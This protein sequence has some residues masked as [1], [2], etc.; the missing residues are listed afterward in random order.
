MLEAERAMLK[1]ERERLEDKDKAWIESEVTASLADC[2]AGQEELTGAEGT[3]FEAA[4][5]PVPPTR[6]PVTLAGLLPEVREGA[7]KWA[8]MA[9]L[10]SAVAMAD[11]RDATRSRKMMD[12]DKTGTAMMRGP[13]Y[14]G[15]F[16]EMAQGPLAGTDE[17]R[18]HG[19][20]DPSQTNQARRPRHSG[21]RD[22]CT[23]VLGPA[24]RTPKRVYN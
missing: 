18:F 1:R 24:Q 2:R 15:M 5:R 10:A 4:D 14:R 7:T 8:T 21:W 16:D 17:L 19:P 23:Q 6:S 22:G 20:P 13:H 9:A 3:L 12:D 11:G